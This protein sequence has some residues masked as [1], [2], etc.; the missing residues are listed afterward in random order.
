M[1]AEIIPTLPGNP[2][3]LGRHINHDERSLAYAFGVTEDARAAVVAAHVEQ[4]GFGAVAQGHHV[5][6][7]R[8]GK[9][10]V[11]YTHTFSGNARQT[12]RYDYN[13]VVYQLDLDDPRLRQQ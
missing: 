4:A 1:A 7:G 6:P 11:P 3:G 10:D 12:P 2:Y 5:H 13:Q 8:H 9:Q